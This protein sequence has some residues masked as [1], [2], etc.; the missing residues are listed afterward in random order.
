MG[1][2]LVRAVI[3]HMG[4]QCVVTDGSEGGWEDIGSSLLRVL[5]YFHP[6]S[7]I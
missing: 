4:Q 7:K 6:V 1:I 2:G 5:Y 3:L